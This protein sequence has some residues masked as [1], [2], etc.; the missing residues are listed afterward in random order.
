MCR[1]IHIRNILKLLANNVIESVHPNLVDSVRIAD[2]LN[3]TM[4]ETQQIL[5]T[6]HHKGIIQS[7]TETKY[8]LITK[9]GLDSL[10]S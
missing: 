1:D 7:N 4:P 9:A 5:K 3:L 6:M 10:S 8:S 2:E